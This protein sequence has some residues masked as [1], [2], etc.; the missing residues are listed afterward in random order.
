MMSLKPPTGL[1]LNADLVV[2]ASPQINGGTPGLG[3]RALSSSGV[4]KPTNVMNRRNS[5]QRKHEIV[6]Q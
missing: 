1:G 3:V 4:P 6:T 5:N 2:T